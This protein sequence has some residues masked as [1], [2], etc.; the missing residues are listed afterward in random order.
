M[1]LAPNGQPSIERINKK[2]IDK[3][4]FGDRLW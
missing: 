3:F 2:H 4:D 1:N